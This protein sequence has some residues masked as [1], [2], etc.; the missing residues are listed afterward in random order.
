[1]RACRYFLRRVRS[2]EPCALSQVKAHPDGM[3]LRHVA[4]CVGVSA[5][6]VRQLEARALV[7]LTRARGGGFSL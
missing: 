5:E 3:S 2:G 1:M 7:K 6:R 4:A